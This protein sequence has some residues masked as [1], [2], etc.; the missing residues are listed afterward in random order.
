MNQI[1]NQNMNQ[2]STTLESNNDEID[3]RQLAGSLKRQWKIIA[4]VTVACILLS[5]LKTLTTKP[6]WEGRFDI[7]LKQPESNSSVKA[8]LLAS[9][10]ALGAFIG[11]GGGASELETQVEI[12]NSTSVLNP[13]FQY[14]RSQKPANE[15]KNLSFDDWVKGALEI[16][17]KKGT[18]VLNVAYRDSDEPLIMPVLQKVSRAYQ[19]YSGKDRR[20]GLQQGVVYIN[21]QVLTYRNQ[22]NQSLRLLQAYALANDLA[23]LLTVPT[24]DKSNGQETG[25]TEVQRAQAAAK[26]RTLKQQIALLDRAADSNVY[27]GISVSALNQ[28]S[29]AEGASGSRTSL[30]DELKRVEA[31]LAKQSVRFTDQDQSIQ[32]LKE[33]R[34]VLIGFVNQ[35]TRGILNAQLV[36]AEAELA[37]ASRPKDVLL[38]FRDLQRNALRD[39]ATLTKLEESYR[40][41]QLEAARQEDPWE[42]ISTPTLLDKPV[43]PKKGRNLA[44]GLLAGL[45]LGSGAALIMDRRAGLVWNEEELQKLLGLPILTKLNLGADELDSNGEINNSLQPLIQGPLAGNKSIA[46]LSS[47]S[48]DS[49]LALALKQ[50][51]G[52]RLQWLG[53]NDASSLHQARVCEQSIIAVE[54]G[55]CGRDQLEQLKQRLQLLE[56]K[57]IGIIIS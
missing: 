3:L 11:G 35:E 43:A 2:I 55:D 48:I 19:L 18:S 38:K 20:R 6:T 12:L 49:A 57:P 44:L 28:S 17:L 46:V 29:N 1:N 39:E 27:A 9:N 16:K 15:T 10:P 24:S 4:G 13:I 40:G 32:Q 31:D 26:V 34:K 41:L 14:V 23:T 56:L 5:A 36:A 42:L 51:L 52:Q 50:E 47:S 25:N 45:V 22:A 53:F 33:R 8:Q 37:A 7:V 21:K 54:L 30:F